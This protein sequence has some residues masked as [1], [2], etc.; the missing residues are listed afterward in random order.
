MAES[1]TNVQV[2]PTTT[3]TLPSPPVNNAGSEAIA[4][5]LLKSSENQAVATAS[6]AAALAPQREATMPTNAKKTADN[7]LN[8]A[9]LAIIAFALW[10]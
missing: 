10:K 9:L 8:L 6:L 3:I 1:T 5:A 4:A 7:K 2:T